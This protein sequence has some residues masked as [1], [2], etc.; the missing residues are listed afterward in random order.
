MSKKVTIT[1]A[2]IKAIG[3]AADILSAMIGGGDEE[4]EFKKCVTLIDR[5]LKK[6]GYKRE[7]K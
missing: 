4:G 5:F 2:Q 7:Y 3:T 6:N 1:P